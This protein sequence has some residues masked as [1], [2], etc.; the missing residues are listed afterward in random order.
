[1]VDTILGSIDIWLDAHGIKS[2]TRV[3]SVENISLEGVARLRE[4]ILDLAM[5]GRLVPQNQHD[6]PARDLLI[7]IQKEKEQLVKEG[8]LRKLD[9][10]GSIDKKD[11]PYEIPKGWTWV[12]N[13]HLFS[14]RKGKK[15]LTLSEEEI[16][17][18]YLD[19]DALDRNNYKQYTTDPNCVLATDDDILVVCDGSR[20]G[21]VLNGKQG[22]VGSTLAVIDSAPSIK[23]F[24]RLLFEKS[25]RHLNSTMKGAAI[26]HL[27]SK[28]LL[29][30][31]TALPPLNEQHRI[32]AKVHELMDVCNMLEEKQTNNLKT[33]QALV[34]T[35]LETLILT[36]DTNDLQSAW[37]RIYTNF[38]T[39]FCTEDSIE[40]FKQTVL[41]LAVMGKLV[42]QDPADEPV[43]RLL[44]QIAKEK[45]KPSLPEIGEDE[46][47]FELPESWQWCRLGEIAQISRGSSPRPKGD[48]RY[49]SKVETDF[50]WITISDITKFCRNN[51][52]YKTREHLTKEGAPMSRYVGKDEFIIAVSGSTTG[53][54]CITG[55][56]GYI[57]DGLASVKINDKAISNEYLL[58]YMTQYY[59]HINTSV[60]GLFPNINTDFLKMLLICIPPKSEQE[61]IV[62]KV[63]ELF[64]LCESLKGKIKRAQDLKFLLAKTIVEKAS[65]R[66]HSIPNH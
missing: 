13:S 66:I 39:F 9:R 55:I 56:T 35:S 52:L 4:V 6:E 30:S 3:K 45:E 20:S 58:L 25:F 10:I 26:P 31:V 28:A 19:I 34:K 40:Q 62:A 60:E 21:L 37:E 15:P 2:R 5:R 63:N 64:T 32:I 43:N 47:R 49:F 14:L 38:D 53:K 22:V 12:R 42:K 11:Q 17:L 48:D 36:D 57:Y 23:P 29:E 44:K 16:G 46:K 50:N 61:R 54:C 51:V 33:H 1:M 24:L 65:E 59:Q 41:Q 7:K 18:P 27:D 8:K